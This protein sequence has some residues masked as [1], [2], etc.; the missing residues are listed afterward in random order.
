MYNNVEKRFLA[1]F[2]AFVMVFSLLPWWTVDISAKV[3]LGETELLDGKIK[4]Q[5]TGGTSGQRTT[6]SYDAATGTVTIGVK[7]VEDCNS[8][9]ETATHTVTIT[10]ISGEEITLSFSYGNFQNFGT[11]QI[12]NG[13]AT[14]V[15]GKHTQKLGVDGTIEITLTSKNESLDETKADLFGFQIED[16]SA[17]TITVKSGVNG[18]V[19][20]NGSAISVETAFETDYATGISVSATPASGYKFVAWVDEN[21]Q[22]ITTVNKAMKVTAVWKKVK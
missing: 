1:L 6:A 8:F 2:L 16:S 4:I 18:T 17:K 14:T 11:I 12:G 19:N 10:N 15:A 3:Q 21:N 5:T 9:K 20:V 22:E 7:S 13:A